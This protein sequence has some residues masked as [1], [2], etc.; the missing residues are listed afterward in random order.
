MW[1]GT[2]V[3]TSLLTPDQV[4]EVLHLKKRAV[5]ALDIPRV[6]AGRGKV[7]I[8]EED[9]ELY[10]RSHVEQKGA[11]R[12]DRI[13]KRSKEVALQGLP[14]RHQLQALRMGYQKTEARRA[15]AEFL[16]E[17][18]KNPHKTTFQVF[19]RSFG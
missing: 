17:L 2:P 8:R 4:G 16:A 6:R 15:E 1:R 14:S 3:L 12:A 18:K 10:I 19:P 5:L 7:L 13:S 11:G 9:V